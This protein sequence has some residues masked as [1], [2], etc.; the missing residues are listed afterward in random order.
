MP[1]KIDD[2]SNLRF[3]HACLQASDYHRIDYG[4]VAEKFGIQA[5]AAR[6]R[7]TRLRDSLGGGPKKRK[8]ADT[9]DGAPTTARKRVQKEGVEYGAPKG[10]D[11][12]DEELPM[13]KGERI[14]DRDFAMDGMRIKKEGQ[15][16]EEDVP[17]RMHMYGAGMH[18]APTVPSMM[19]HGLPT[20][21]HPAY[22]PTPQQRQVPHAPYSFWNP[23]SMPTVP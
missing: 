20:V 8:R 16:E 21:V 2:A 12:D 7:F 13:I 19:P 5:P 15:D 11:D 23:Q 4:R 14:D 6:M 9:E 1:S 3:L 22:P 18:R 10:D 17:L